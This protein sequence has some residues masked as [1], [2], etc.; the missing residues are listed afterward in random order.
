MP[1]QAGGWPWTWALMAKEVTIQKNIIRYLKDLGAWCLKVHG[2]PYQRAG[3][4]DLLCCHEGL[5]YAFEV[6]RPGA[7]PTPLQAHELEQVQTAGGTAAVVT[8]VED[9]QNIIEVSKGDQKL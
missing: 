3:V 1:N 2:S 9:V 4:P 7:R 8:S 6:K 5:F